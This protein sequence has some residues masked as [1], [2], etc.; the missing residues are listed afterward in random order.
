MNFMKW[1]NKGRIPT[2]VT[3]A[4]SCVERSYQAGLLE[5]LE[6]IIVSLISQGE[7][8]KAAQ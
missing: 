2:G 8:I 1:N 7:E 5:S 6:G 3:N 4:G